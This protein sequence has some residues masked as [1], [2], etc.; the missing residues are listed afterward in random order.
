MRFYSPLTHILDNQTKVVILR[1]LCKYPTSITG[2]QLAKVVKINPTTVNKALNGLIAEQ[3]ILVRIAGKS[4][5]YE[6][7]KTHWVVTKL[8][9]PLFKQEDL[10]LDDFINNVVLGI[11]KSELKD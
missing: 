9:I 2:R 11:K 8:L 1:L 6:L 7:N 3:I 10:L 4:C 5:I